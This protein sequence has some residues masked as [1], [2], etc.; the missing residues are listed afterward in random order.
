MKYDRIITGIISGILI[1]PITG[2]IIYLF[3]ADGLSLSS[4][5][6]H[7]SETNIVTH[8][9]TLCVFPNVII[10]LIYNRFDM[11]RACR[12]VLAITIAW[13]VVVFGVK[14]LG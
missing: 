2:L 12:G 4:Y 13:A 7:I 14:F 8:S 6:S 9:I 11:L 3:S 5:L 10:F 1:P